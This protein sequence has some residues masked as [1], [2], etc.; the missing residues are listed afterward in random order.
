MYDSWNDLIIIESQKDYWKKLN[1]FL[2]QED[3]K[4]NVFPPKNTRFKAL[5]LTPLNQVK[6]VILG[7]DPYHGLNQS[8]GLAFSVS[9]S[10]PI[11]PSLKNIFKELNNDLG[12]SCTHGD[13]TKWAK[14][15]VLLLN[16]V[17]TVRSNEPLSHEKKGWEYF[18]DAIIATINQ[19]NRPIVFVL[20]GK[21]AERKNLLLNNPRHLVITSAHPS[22]LS[23]RFGFFGSK[24]FS[25]INGFL[26]NDRIDWSNDD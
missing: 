16:T 3:A 19:I 10:T 2:E 8:M 5:E 23:A 15:G 4:Y 12:I 22:P 7:Q 24:P 11:P 1:L 21:K 17:L 26:Q 25:K 20:W 18:T 9:R 14:S 13:L 6:V